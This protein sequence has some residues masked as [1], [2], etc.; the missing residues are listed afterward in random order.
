MF[1]S[2]VNGAEVLPMKEIKTGKVCF[3]FRSAPVKLKI[4]LTA[5][6]VLSI[7]ALAALRWVSTGIQAQTAVKQEQAAAM[8]GENADLQEKIDS[9]GSVQSIQQIAREE[10]GLVDPD[11]VIIHPE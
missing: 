11:T 8:E 6:I 1:S 2:A 5:L 7:C 4:A 10:L 9:L 3:R